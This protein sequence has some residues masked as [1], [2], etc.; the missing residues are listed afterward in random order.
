MKAG[1]ALAGGGVSGTAA[2]GVIQALEEN[3]IAVT[4]LAGTSSG[5]LVAALYAYGYTVDE[6]RQLIPRFT[7]RH[8]DA[9]WKTILS[10][11]LLR[12]SKL[13]GWMKG[14]RL[15]ALLDEFTHSQSVSDFPIPCGIVA[16]DLRL[17]K[18]IVF[19]KD[20]VP[21]FQTAAD[22]PISL[23]LLA[24]SAIPVL[25]QP[26][27]WNGM[28]LADGGVSMNCPVRVVRAM[29]A[30]KVI[31]VD[32]VTAFA[33]DDVGEL[34]SAFSIFTHIVN[35]NLRDQMAHEHRYADISLFPHVG[36]VGAFDFHKVEQCV[37][38][39]YRYAMDN[40]ERIRAVLTSASG[41][42]L[43]DLHNRF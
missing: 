4:H 20:P 9:D 17:G 32:T 33:N 27:R 7:R 6:L 31:A 28:I 35:L 23:A 3:G 34:R 15:R 19:A 37:E 39:G 29:G 11:F 2:I 5:S 21:G 13:D 10:K 25:F 12:R 1:L 42:S 43:S 41:E 14:V 36:Y 40:M 38:A 22:L 26:V 8:L 16:T 30:E 18:P 24:S